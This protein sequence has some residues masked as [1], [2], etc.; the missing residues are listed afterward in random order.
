MG[1]AKDTQ[2]RHIYHGFYVDE[3]SKKKLSS[4]D[5]ASNI[6][7][8]LADTIGYFRSKYEGNTDFSE[9]EKDAIAKVL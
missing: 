5:G 4:R 9:S 2:M 8:L 1:I 6:M 3:K 7:K